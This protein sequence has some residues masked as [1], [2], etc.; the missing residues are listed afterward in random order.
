MKK[1]YCKYLHSD[2]CHHPDLE[3]QEKCEYYMHQEMCPSYHR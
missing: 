1:Q 2:W 3:F